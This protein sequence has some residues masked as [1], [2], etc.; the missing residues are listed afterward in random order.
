MLY[1]YYHLKQLIEKSVHLFSI[2]SF[3][4]SV[5]KTHGLFLIYH[6]ELFFTYGLF[7]LF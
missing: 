6:H 7:C 2:S 4:F 3:I 5:T 1:L